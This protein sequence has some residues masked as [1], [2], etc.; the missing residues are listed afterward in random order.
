MTRPTDAV[1]WPRV[2]CC[3]SAHECVCG[4]EERALR[5]FIRGQTPAPMTPSQREW[6][7]AEIE[8]V[9]GWQR[10]DYAD[11]DDAMLARGVIA[12]WTD[13]C[14]DKGLIG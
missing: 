11:A 8:R 10:A 1:A 12:A 4:T 13:Y 9:E 5:A 14:R 3:M 6:C 7:L 2:S